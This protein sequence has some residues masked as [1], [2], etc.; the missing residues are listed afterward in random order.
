MPEDR[1]NISP[2][3]SGVQGSWAALESSCGNFRASQGSAGSHPA[4]GNLVLLLVME[5]TKITEFFLL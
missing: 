1:G 4:L 5:M 2:E 3:L